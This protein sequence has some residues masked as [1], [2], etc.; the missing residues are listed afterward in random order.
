MRHDSFGAQPRV[1]MWYITS[2]VVILN[3]FMPFVLCAA[4]G[5][6]A[7]AILSL[8]FSTVWES[9]QFSALPL[10]VEVKIYDH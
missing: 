6:G 1:C 9:S 7:E 3:S 5:I 4:E 8:R 2:L 10:H